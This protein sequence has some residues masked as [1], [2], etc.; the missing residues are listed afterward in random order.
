MAGKETGNRHVIVA[1]ISNFVTLTLFSLA[2]LNSAQLIPKSILLE[3]ASF[4]GRTGQRIVL[5]NRP[6][7][8]GE[9]D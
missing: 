4:S 7:V 2:E 1:D 6:S 3:S 5:E 9:V 8:R